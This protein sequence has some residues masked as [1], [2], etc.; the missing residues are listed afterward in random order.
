MIVASAMD[1]TVRA[2][3]AHSFFCGLAGMLWLFIQSPC[4][5]SQGSGRLLRLQA[6]GTAVR[7][8]GAVTQNR[9][10]TGL[11]RDC[12]SGEPCART[13]QGKGAVTY[14]CSITYR[15]SGD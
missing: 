1:A 3:Q 11:A 7:T 10:L 14:Y 13:W 5:K 8:R 9:G 12:C 2:I 15:L 6:R 4:R